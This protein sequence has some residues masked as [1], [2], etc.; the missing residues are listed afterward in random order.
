MIKLALWSLLWAGTV[1]PWPTCSLDPIFPE[2]WGRA[3]GD[4]LFMYIVVGCVVCA[5]VRVGVFEK[6]FINEF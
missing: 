1:P 2:T 3:C 6:Q 5:S 4:C